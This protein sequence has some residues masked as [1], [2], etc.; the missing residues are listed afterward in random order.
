MAVVV[1][2]RGMRYGREV[3]LANVV[4]PPYDVISPAAQAEFYDANPHNVIRLI[5]NR[6]ADPYASAAKH[7]KNWIETSVLVEDAEPAFYLLHQRFTD[8]TGRV[9][10]RVGFIGL[11][12]LE[13]YSAKVV[14]PHEK[15]F[16]KPRADRLNLFVATHANFCQVFGIY[17]DPHRT[18]EKILNSCAQREPDQSIVF[19]G[20]T[21]SVWRISDHN[22]ND[23][24]QREMASKEVLIADGHHRYETALAYRQIAR[25]RS[26]QHQGEEPHDYVMMFFASMHADG[27]VV[28]PTHR[29][30]HSVSGL[31]TV[32]FSRELGK[33]FSLHHCA[34]LDDL[35][36]SMKDHNGKAI[37]MKLKNEQGFALLLPQS[38]KSIDEA[39]DGEVAPQ[40][41]NLDVSI[42]HE[43]VLG[44][45]LGMTK[46]AQ[47]QK[48]NLDFVHDANES[49]GRVERGE[50]QVTFF[51]N[52]PDVSE[53]FSIAE[54]GHTMPQKSTYFFPKL[55]SG[56]IMYRMRGEVDARTAR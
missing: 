4:A 40:V 56:L 29:V 8:V 45:I 25:E 28:H 12:R 42:L 50:A 27:L 43:I 13:E 34:T 32:L 26:P 53:I 15:T 33:Y 23:R 52:P 39:F 48:K 5:L 46:E 24:I 38:E 18:V 10:T 37:G 11:C 1:P 14:L 35:Q 44:R 47:A 3:D 51:L 17:R 22:V 7:L 9:V 36:R 20:V 6:D 16:P 21:N 41:R 31:D 30:V 49:L 54:S 55:L 2:F 19:D